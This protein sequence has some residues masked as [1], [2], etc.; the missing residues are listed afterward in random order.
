[1]FY[2]KSIVSKDRIDSSVCYIGDI[3]HQN[4]VILRREDY[5]RGDCHHKALSLNSLQ[6]ILYPTALTAK[7]MRIYS[8]R[9]TI[10]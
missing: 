4:I 7:I 9:K 2:Q 8:L 5:I 6:Y 10:V 3:C 1:M